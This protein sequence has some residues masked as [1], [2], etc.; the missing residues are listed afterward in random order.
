MELKK[1]TGYKMRF[2]YEEWQNLE[3]LMDDM[4]KVGNSLDTLPEDSEIQT[5]NDDLDMLDN[6]EETIRALK[7]SLSRHVLVDENS[8]RIV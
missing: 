1:N 6:L 7:Q 4:D 8:D 2:G 5:S 3:E